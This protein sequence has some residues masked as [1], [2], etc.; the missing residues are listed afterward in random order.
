MGCSESLRPFPP[1]FVAFVWRYH[2]CDAVFRVRPFAA[3]TAG[4]RARGR[5]GVSYAG[6]PIPALNV[7]TTGLPRFLGNPNADMPCSSTPTGPA[8]PSHFS[9]PDTAFRGH[10]CVGS[11][12]DKFFRGSITRPAHSLST[13]RSRGHPR[14]TQDSLPAVGLLCRAGLITR[15]VPLQGLAFHI[16]PP[17]PGFAWRTVTFF[18]G[19]HHQA[20][21]ST[22]KP[23]G[24]TVNCGFRHGS[25]LPARAPARWRRGATSQSS[26]SGQVPVIPARASQSSTPRDWSLCPKPPRRPCRQVRRTDRNLAGGVSPRN[27]SPWP[28]KALKGRKRPL[29][30]GLPFA[31]TGLFGVWGAADRG[32]TPTAKFSA[33]PRASYVALMFSA[34]LPIYVRIR[35]GCY[36]RPACPCP[37][38]VGRRVREA[39]PGAPRSVFKPCPDFGSS[40]ADSHCGADDPHS[41]MR[42]AEEISVRKRSN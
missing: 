22:H 20:G 15:W 7:E 5:P 25:N 23:A 2:V 6:C 34:V 35:R 11:R 37:P 17:C 27:E 9:P 24:A 38:A 29:S 19:S 21:K 26:I 42:N 14:T 16:A 40:K 41:D 28:I 3:P 31:P 39:G 4:R 18:S 30:G 36:P 13:L 33:A 32:L 12:N 10:Y 8:G 1:H